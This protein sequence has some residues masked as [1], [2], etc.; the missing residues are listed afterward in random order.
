MS[1]Q[2]GRMARAALPLG[3]VLAAAC[4]SGGGLQPSGVTA[5]DVP[6]LE[7]AVAA[8]TAD[9][10]AMTRLGVAYYENHRY[11]GAVAVL[12]R[13]IG[14]GDAPPVARVYLGLSAEEVGDWVTARDAYAAYLAGSGTSGDL[15]GEVRRRVALA[16]QKALAQE[17]Q[18]LVRNEADLST[19]VPEPRTVGVFPFQVVSD[20]PRYEPLQ[21][22]LADMV[23]TDLSIPGSLRLLERAEIQ[24]LLHE[25]A[26]NVGGYTAPESGARVGRLLRAANVVQGS[27]VLLGDDQIRMDMGVTDA[28]IGAQRGSVEQSTA[29]ENV[30]DAEKQMVLQLLGTLGVTPTDAERERILENRTGNLLALLAYGEG[31]MAMDRGDYAT[32]QARFQQAAS[33]DPGFQA[34]Q[35]KAQSAGQMQQAQQTPTAQVAQVAS[36]DVPSS[37]SGEFAARESALTGATRDI[38]PSPADIYVTA[39]VNDGPQSTE[40]T[41]NPGDRTPTQ[42]QTGDLG[43]GGTVVRI[44]IPN[45][46]QP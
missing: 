27:V 16:S 25:M 21:V 11:A 17:A 15:V 12:Q 32:A 46:S 24:A 2:M 36:P 45:P 8:G 20:D 14:A 13:A 33:L 22:A 40:R 4:A 29:L 9:A 31:L 26:L 10:A 38:N 6:A 35:N 43:E 37:A 28:T 1:H 18:R 39:F 23:T 42:T 34:A 41:D 7:R 3:L 30:F 19:E 44:T 5:A